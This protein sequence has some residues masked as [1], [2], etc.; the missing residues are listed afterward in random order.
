M[1]A[2]E[3]MTPNPACCTPE[4]SLPE[5][6]RLFIDHDCGAIPVVDNPGNR[7]PVGI[8]TDRDIACR[9][10]G[11]G[12]NALELTARDCMSAPVVTVSLEASLNDCCEAMEKNKVRRV[13]V[14]DRTGACCGIVAQA[15]IAVRGKES[16]AAEVVKQVSEPTSSPSAIPA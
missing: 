4:T 14:I 12:K 8:V 1:K 6:A 16:K 13:L 7:R 11:A 15:D 9:A 2:S 10:V 3:I 5:V